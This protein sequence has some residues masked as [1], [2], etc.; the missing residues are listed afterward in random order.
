MEIGRKMIKVLGWFDNEWGY[1]VRCS[2]VF[3]KMALWK[4]SVG[5]PVSSTASSQ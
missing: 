2:D 3:N 1:S 5:E 4:E